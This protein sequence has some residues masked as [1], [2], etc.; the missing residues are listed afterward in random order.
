MKLKKLFITSHLLVGVSALVLLLSGIRIAS[1]KREYLLSIDWL[2]PTGLVHIW[3]MM[4]GVMLLVSLPIML[5]C[6]HRNRKEKGT[7]KAYNILGTLVIGISTITGTLQFLFNVVSTE[8]QTVHFYSALLFVLFLLI[9]PLRYYFNRPVHHLLNVILRPLITAK[10]YMYSLA[11]CV[12][13]GVVYLSALVTPAKLLIPLISDTEFI[14]I[15]GRQTENVWA[16]TAPLNVFTFSGANFTSGATNVSVKALHNKT[17]TYFFLR[18]QDSTKSETHLPITKTNKGWQV[19]SDGFELFDEKTFYED[20]FAMLFSKSCNLAAAGTAHLG[21]KPNQRLPANTHGKGYHYTKAGF[22]DLW[23]WKAVRTNSM[24]IMDDSYIGKPV[25]PVDGEIRYTAGY[26]QDSDYG[27]SYKMNWQ[28]FNQN[29]VTPKR[30]P[31]KTETSAKGHASWF[32]YQAYRPDRDNFAVGTKIKSV[33][34][35]SNQIEGGRADVR[36]FGRYSNGYWQLE[37]VRKKQTS[38]K[39]DLELNDGICMWV[40]AFDRAQ[41]AHTRH[42]KPL[43][44]HFSN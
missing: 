31:V 1:L 2:L 33:L 43:K 42:I 34:Y 18:W 12:V 20:K 32:D 19:K 23:Q 25:A 29:S 11:I 28:W 36:A 35:R 40:S 16:H 37:V 6:L 3:H 9:H 39:T 30:L 8:L 38:E 27:G 5:L 14:R 26:Q 15:D 10:T 21:R 41:I 13:A 24:Y 4:A 17:E 7:L 44:L 22:A